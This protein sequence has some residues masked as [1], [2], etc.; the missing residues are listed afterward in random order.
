MQQQLRPGTDLD[1]NDSLRDE[2]IDKI[3]RET[4]RRSSIRRAVIRKVTR[5]Y[6]FDEFEENDDPPDPKALPKHLFEYGNFMPTQEVNIEKLPKLMSPSPRAKNL[7]VTVDRSSAKISLRPTPVPSNQA[8][9][10]LNYSNKQ[11]D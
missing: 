6:E 7:G 1:F 4:N 8:T 5:V 2:D 3:R 10:E 11:A 9:K